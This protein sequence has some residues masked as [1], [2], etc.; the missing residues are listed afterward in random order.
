MFSVFVIS[1][2]HIAEAMV[3]ALNSLTHCEFPI[4]AVYVDESLAM[5]EIESQIENL[6]Q[7][8]LLEG[9]VVVITDFK[10]GTPFNIAMRLMKKYPIIHLTGLNMPLLLNLNICYTKNK[11]AKEICTLALEAARG[12]LMDLE[13]LVRRLESGDCIGES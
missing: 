2:G 3:E 1:H 6:V 4:D 13:E 9:D 8:K 5:N 10:L 12:E 11:A 7:G